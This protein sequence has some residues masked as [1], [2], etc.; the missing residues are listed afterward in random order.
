MGSIGKMS[1]DWCYIDVRTYI[2]S[3]P[4][5]LFIIDMRC[6]CSF[7]CFFLLFLLLLFFDY[8]SHVNIHVISGHLCTPLMM[9][10][11]TQQQ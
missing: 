3:F 9:L 1:S 10:V 7:D 8:S 4:V 11:C 5:L 6:F 2:D